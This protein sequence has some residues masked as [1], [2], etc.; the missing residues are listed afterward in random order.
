MYITRR[1]LNKFIDITSVKDEEITIALNS[2]GFE[3]DAYKNY[4]GLNDNL[5]LDN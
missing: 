2:L 1:W 4:Q 3:V 5:V